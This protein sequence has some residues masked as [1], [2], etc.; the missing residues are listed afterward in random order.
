MTSLWEVMRRHKLALL[1]LAL[2]LVWD[3]VVLFRILN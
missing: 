1:L 3:V 2:I